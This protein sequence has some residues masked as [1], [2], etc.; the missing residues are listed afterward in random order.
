MTKENPV[1]PQQNNE[2]LAGI[3]LLDKPI[4][5]S[6]FSLVPILRK[7]TAL[8]KIG[9]AG[10]LDP[11][12]SGVMVM[13]IGKEYTRKSDHFLNHD[14][15]YEAT[16]LLGTTTDSYDLEGTITAQSEHIPSQEEVEKAIASY[17]GTLEQ[18]PPMFSAK[19]IQ[20]KRLY[21]LA[22]KGIEVKRQPQTITLTTT[23]ISYNYPYLKLHVS[24]TKG[25]YIRTLGHDIGQ[26]LQCGAHLVELKR[27]RSGPFHLKDCLDIDTLRD[28]EF[29]IQTHLRYADSL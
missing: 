17:Q 15:E 23:L 6:S 10:T 12:A 3:L 14:K 5:R 19:K 25:T 22:R 24:C 28:P 11:F 21:E 26:D 20:G 7:L 29:Q 18:T 16:L 2:P 8:K 13:L 9:H 1:N 27:V 4:G